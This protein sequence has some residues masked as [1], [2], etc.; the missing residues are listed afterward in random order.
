MGVLQKRIV[1]ENEEKIHH[2]A[3]E[4]I[5]Q[6]NKIYKELLKLSETVII[7]KL[8]LIFLVNEVYKSTFY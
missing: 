7:H 8:R 6:S 5:N 4:V 2:K 1:F 3:L